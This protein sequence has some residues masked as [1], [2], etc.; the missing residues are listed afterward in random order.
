MT[1]RDEVAPHAGPN[2]A[3][4]AVRRAGNLTREALRVIDSLHALAYGF[5]ALDKRHHG[6][7][8]REGYC[9]AC[10]FSARAKAKLRVLPDSLHDLALPEEGTA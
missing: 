5:D 1:S 7:T 10:E 9:Y 2:A 4:G 3:Q 8:S 6:D